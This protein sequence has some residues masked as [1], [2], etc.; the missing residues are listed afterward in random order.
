MRINVVIFLLVVSA[1][2]LGCATYATVGDEPPFVGDRNGTELEPG[3]LV[4]LWAGWLNEPPPIDGGG[5]TSQPSPAVGHS[6]RIHSHIVPIRWFALFQ[7]KDPSTG[8]LVVRCRNG[9]DVQWLVD[10]TVLI[11]RGP[12]DD[13]ETPTGH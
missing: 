7:Y 9:V 6:S 12:G 11:E 2:A 4:G 1:I 10:D 13:G 8:A 5:P 3:D